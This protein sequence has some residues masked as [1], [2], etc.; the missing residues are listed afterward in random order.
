[1]SYNKN[2]R[3]RAYLCTIKWNDPND[4]ERLEADIYIHQRYL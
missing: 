3:S 1:M 4:L 2:A